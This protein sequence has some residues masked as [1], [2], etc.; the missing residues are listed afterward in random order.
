MATIFQNNQ[1]ALENILGANLYIRYGAGFF[2]F[3]LNYLSHMFGY[4]VGM[5]Y[6]LPEA[7]TLHNSILQNLMS[8]GFFGISTV[9]SKTDEYKREIPNHYQPGVFGEFSDVN[10][11]VDIDQSHN[12]NLSGI[13]GTVSLGYVAQREIGSNDIT[14]KW[15]CWDEIDARDFS[16][17]TQ[18]EMHTMH[19]MEASFDLVWDRLL[20]AW[21]N[22]R[23]TKTETISCN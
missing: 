12:S 11:E 5:D 16:S 23:V 17:F 15:Y 18:N 2:W 20:Q 21:Y 22:F 3:P 10:Y 4:L 14:I 19:S 7:S 8:K 13:L 1:N 6:S 9:I